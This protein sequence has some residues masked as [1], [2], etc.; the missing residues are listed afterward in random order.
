MAKP[1]PSNPQHFLYTFSFPDGTEKKF[2]ITLDGDTLELIREKDPSPPPWTKLKFHQCDHCPLGD[3]EEYCPIAVNLSSLVE[4]FKNSI[5]YESTLMKV[6]TAQRTYE[7]HTDLQK[8]LSSI[9]GIYNVTSNCPVMDKLRP[10]VRFHLPFAS[11]EETLFR[12]VSMYLLAQ[13]FRMRKGQ[14]P[15]WQ[16]AHFDEIYE[17]V[18]QVDRGLANRLRHASEEDALV[19]SLVIWSAL[20][21]LVRDSI[22]ENLADLEPLFLKYFQEPGD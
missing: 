7:K 13:Y 12:S 14:Q 10:M 15:D 16:L 21:Q 4:T 2:T 19:N 6:Q 20:A 17:A 9:I 8:G 5:S 11:V 1:Q 22:E 18:A 3:E